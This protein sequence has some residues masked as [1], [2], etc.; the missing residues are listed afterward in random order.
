M[1]STLLLGL[2]LSV[3]APAPKEAPKADPAKIEGDWVI[4]KYVNGGKVD[5]KRTGMEVKITADEITPGRESAARYTLDPKADPPRIDLTTDKKTIPGI[6]KL[7]GGTLTICFPKG[8]G[9]R[10]SKFESPDGSRIVVMTLK[11]A[12]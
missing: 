6:Y 7:E 11:R 10:P 4:E 1:N 2:A 8:Q 5:D 3:G 9:E 12:K